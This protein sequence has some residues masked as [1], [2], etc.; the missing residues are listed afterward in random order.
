[1]NTIINTLGVAPCVGF[2]Q[3]VD[4]HIWRCAADFANA[5]ETYLFANPAI[6]SGQL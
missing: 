2:E 3:L 6:V 5:L 1:M 4:A